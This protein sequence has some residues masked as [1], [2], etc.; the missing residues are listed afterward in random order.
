MS[1]FAAFGKSSN[2]PTKQ[3]VIRRVQQSSDPGP[4]RDIRRTLSPSK[5]PSSK[6]ASPR[7]E[8]PRN[9]IRAVSREP[10]NGYK[11]SPSY[12]AFGDDSEGDSDHEAAFSHTQK[13]ARIGD[14]PKIDHKRRVRDVQN[15]SEENEEVFPFKHGAD[16]THSG[17]PGDFKRLFNDEKEAPQELPLQYPSASQ[18]ERYYKW[19]L[20]FVIAPLN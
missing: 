4:Q 17:K 7:S 1:F 12:P 15:W 10:R 19:E 13:R 11:R 20:L 8:S 16:L 6:A 9:P 2:P 18:A 5:A 14:G 3:K